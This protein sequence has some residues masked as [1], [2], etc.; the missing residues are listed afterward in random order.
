[1]GYIYKITNTINNKCYVGQ[2]LN[3]V[4]ERWR[5]HKKKSTNCRYL[6]HAFIKY[7]FD[8]FKFELICI[9]FDEDLDKYEIEYIKKFKCLVPD[10]YN[11][12]SGGLGDGRLSKESK[13]QISKTLKNMYLNGYIH[14]NKGIKL[15]KEHR[16]KL[17]I[18][19]NGKKHTKETLIKLKQ[20]GELNMKRII[21]LDMNE[22]IINIY[23]SGKEAAEKNN[24]TKAGVSMVCND[25]RIQLKGFKYKFEDSNF[26]DLLESIRAL[27]C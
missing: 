10:G 1:M 15:S 21:Q 27:K 22:N 4:K 5:Q 9:C 11:L 13:E 25:K 14:P 7:G 23:K 18:A 20:N 2:T 19:H 16:N 26:A 8:K 6:K 12:K 3:D 24:T 17:S